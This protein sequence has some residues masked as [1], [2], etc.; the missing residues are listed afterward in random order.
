MS[1]LAAFGLALA[2]IGCGPSTPSRP[3]FVL[4]VTD[5]LRLDHLD[6]AGGSFATPWFSTLRS[7]SIWFPSACAGLVHPSLRGIAV[8]LASEHGARSWGDKLT[9]TEPTLPSLLGRAGYRSS[10]WSANYLMASSGLSR[11]FDLYTTIGPRLPAA[12]CRR[13]AGD[14][15]REELRALG[16]LP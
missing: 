5:T 8:Q 16:Y 12:D 1:R 13:G 4:V 7:E 14:K 15:V 11:G 2:L 9:E 6:F 3:S 10:A